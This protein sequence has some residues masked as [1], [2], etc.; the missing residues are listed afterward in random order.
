LGGMGVE[1]LLGRDVLGGRF[2]K[3]GDCLGVVIA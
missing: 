3:S 1:V 2:P